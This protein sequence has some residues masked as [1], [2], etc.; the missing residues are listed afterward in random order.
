MVVGEDPEPDQPA[1][2]RRCEQRP[3]L[4]LD[5]R[6]A[7]DLPRRGGEQEHRRGPQGIEDRALG[8][9]IRGG[10]EQ[11][12]PVGDRGRR[13]AG[14]D[15]AP[16]AVGL[17]ACQREDPDHSRDQQDVPERVGEVRDDHARAPFGT[18]EHDLEQN[19]SA[20]RRGGNR[21][22]RPVEPDIPAELGQPRADQQQQRDVAGRVE[23]EEE[24]VG[25]RRIRRRAV[26]GEVEQELGDR[27]GADPDR[28]REPRAPL[29]ADPRSAEHAGG[30]AEQDQPVVEP[31]VEEV[32]EAEAG[33]EQGVRGKRRQPGERR[34][35]PRPGE[36]A[37]AELARRSNCG[38]HGPRYRQYVRRSF[39]RGVTPRSR[40]PG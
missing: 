38:I 19:G 35:P 9:A 22:H 6:P 7:G 17:P 27:P 31:A 10:L 37:Q 20:E 34:Y 3:S 25:D 39:R 36:P 12:D 26:V 30:E 2:E 4:E 33:P 24:A 13:E 32:L 15:Q 18:A 5:R 29:G 1:H 40:A 23:R 21:G 8:V 28:Q 14:P 11:E 16:G